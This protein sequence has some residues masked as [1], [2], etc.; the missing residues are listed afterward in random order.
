[1]SKFYIL[2]LRSSA[3]IHSFLSMNSFGQIAGYQKISGC[4]FSF[5][6]TFYIAILIDYR[7]NSSAI[8]EGF[9]PHYVRSHSRHWSRYIIV[10]CFFARWS[11][12]YQ[13]N[14]HWS[15]SNQEVSYQKSTNLN[16][17][18]YKR[19]FMLLLTYQ[20]EVGYRPTF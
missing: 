1:M 11:L 9:G 20:L 4:F 6:P 8:I 12:T 16:L 18:R 15:R 5:I 3:C 13:Y 17:N 19:S 7:K 14:V 10:N 2:C